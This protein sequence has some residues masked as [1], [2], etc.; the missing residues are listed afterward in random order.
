MAELTDPHGIAHGD[1]GSGSPAFVFLHS[2]D[3]G[4]GMW[5]AQVA[6]LTRD[7]R[8]ITVEAEGLEGAADAV[9]GVLAA[10][11]P[12]PVIVAGTRNEALTALILNERYPEAVTGMVLVDP[13]LPPGDAEGGIPH[14]ENLVKLADKKPFMVIWPE[15]PDGDPSWFRDV[16]MFVRQEP[17]A[18]S[19]A[20][21]Q[22]DQPAITNALLRAFVDDVKYDPRVG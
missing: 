21:P 9:S 19:F 13:S 5:A 2:K 14:A 16:A 3:A 8:C 22:L 1:V 4:A 11:Q 6:D 15:T 20:V 18:G 17:V 10:L 7:H 12:G